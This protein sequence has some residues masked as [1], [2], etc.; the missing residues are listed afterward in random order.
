MN[1]VYLRCRAPFLRGIVGNHG[2]GCLYHVQKYWILRDLT[3]DG[4]FALGGCVCAILVVEKGMDPLL[5]LVTATIA[6]MA[7]GAVT[8]LLRTLFDIPA[9]LARYS[10]P[11]WSVVRESADYGKKQYPS[12]EGGYDF[13]QD[14]G[15][16]G[17]KQSAVSLVIGILIAVLIIVFLYWLFGTEFRQCSACHR[18]Q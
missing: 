3:V 14:C 16:A 10:D 11:D 13:F 17:S 18:K 5:A 12:F 4:S 9:I 2:A 6:G 7:A 8:G 15:F 1:G